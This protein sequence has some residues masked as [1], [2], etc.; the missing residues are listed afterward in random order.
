M[1][2]AVLPHLTLECRMAFAGQGRLSGFFENT[3]RG[4]F[5]LCLREISCVTRAP[6]CEGCP[7]SHACVYALTLEPRAPD[8]TLLSRVGTA[9]PPYLFF[10]GKDAWDTAPWEA[11]PG[12]E[13]PVYLRLFGRAIPHLPFYIHALVRMQEKGLGRDRVT[14]VLRHVRTLPA[15]EDV[16][17]ISD[18]E[19]MRVPAAFSELALDPDSL[20]EAG[21]HQDVDLVC[22]SPLRIQKDGRILRRPT[23]ELLFHSLMRRLAFLFDAYGHGLAWDYRTIQERL[24]GVSMEPVDVRSTASRRYSGRQRRVVELQAPYGRF[25]LRDVPPGGMRLLEAGMV[26]SVGKSTSF[27]FG[28]YQLE[29]PA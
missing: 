5:G 8:G 25:A 10:C 29:P 17:V 6:S 12:V 4:T 28:R 26:V 1:T 24:R 16:Y 23:A 9:P 19:R 27:G 18:P 15:G 22:L 7:L 3:L 11:R 21:P 13:V 20:L 14:F 2:Q